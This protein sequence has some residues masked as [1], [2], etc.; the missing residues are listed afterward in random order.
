VAWALP[1]SFGASPADDRAGAGELR[2][3]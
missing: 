1:S 2:V 3:R